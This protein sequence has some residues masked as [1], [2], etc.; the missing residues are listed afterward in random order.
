MEPTNNREEQEGFDI[1][2][3]FCIRFNCSS[4]E[5]KQSRWIIMDEIMRNIPKV[6]FPKLP[7]MPG[8]IEKIMVEKDRVQ[9]RRAK[10]INLINEFEKLVKFEE[11]E[12]AAG[13]RNQLRSLGHNFR[14]YDR[15]SSC[16]YN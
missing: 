5:L 10:I 11:Y 2:S 6:V 3:F 15:K 4:E 14:F 7:Y 16:F 13:I 1:D 8:M 12:A 9:E